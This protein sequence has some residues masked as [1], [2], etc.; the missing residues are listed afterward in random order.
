LDRDRLTGEQ[1]RYVSAAFLRNLTRQLR[2]TT[3]GGGAVITSLTQIQDAPTVP[4]IARLGAGDAPEPTRTR[5]TAKTTVLRQHRAALGAKRRRIN[6]DIAF[7]FANTMTTM[8]TASGGITVEDLRDLEAGGRGK[9]NN[10]RAA[11]SARRRAC[12]ALEHTA[13]NE[14]DTPHHYL[15]PPPDPSCTPSVRVGQNTNGKHLCT[16]HLRT[17]DTPQVS[18]SIRDG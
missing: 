17:R 7:D 13:T 18:A 8:A 4:R 12:R 11:Q 9:A 2:R 5:L 6:R 16:T 3:G 10:N 1:C 14:P 15:P